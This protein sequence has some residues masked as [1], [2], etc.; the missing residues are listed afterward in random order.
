ME[1][2]STHSPCIASERFGSSFSHSLTGLW[3]GMAEGQRSKRKVASKQWSCSELKDGNQKLMAVKME[4][5]GKAQVDQEIE[6]LFMCLSQWFYSVCWACVTTLG[7][8]IVQ[9]PSRCRSM[10]GSFNSWKLPRQLWTHQPFGFT[11][12]DMF[13]CNCV[14]L[15][16]PNDVCIYTMW[17][18]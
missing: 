7:S 2:I 9:M 18:L 1:N 11:G 10:N 14:L 16:T 8:N 6:E 12:P 13:G 17:G 5:P 3:V 4:T 15:K